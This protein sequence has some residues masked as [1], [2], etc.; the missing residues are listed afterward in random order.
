MD[1]DTLRQPPRNVKDTI[2]SRA[3]ILK[4]LLSAAVIISG[5]LFIFWKE[6]RRVLAGPAAGV[7]W[8]RGGSLAAGAVRQARGTV[9]ARALGAPVLT[10]ETHAQ[11]SLRQG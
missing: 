9:P 3:L 6:V 8:A 4:I 2:L 7:R 5:T 11:L 10:G 1:K